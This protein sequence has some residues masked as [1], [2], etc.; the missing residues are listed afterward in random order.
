MNSL[1]NLVRGLS[2]PQGTTKCVLYILIV[3]GII[4]CH[5][6]SHSLPYGSYIGS[7]DEPPVHLDSEYGTDEISGYVIST[8]E[9]TLSEKRKFTYREIFH[10]GPVEMVRTGHWKWKN[11]SVVLTYDL[12]DSSYV[13]KWWYREQCQCLANHLLQ[14]HSLYLRENEY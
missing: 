11:D 2:K 5:S 9:I 8:T 4:S 6:S 10:E 7:V 12:P 14:P 1:I 3:S 13:E